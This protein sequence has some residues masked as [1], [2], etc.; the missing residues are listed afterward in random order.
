MEIRD[1]QVLITGAGQGIGRAV[2]QM[3]A[4][5]KA[6]LHLILKSDRPELEQELKKLGAASVK[7]YPVDLTKKEEVTQLLKSI[8]KIEIDLL[9]NSATQ[10]IGGLLEEQNFD[11]IDDMLQMNI[12]AMIQF[13]HAILPSMLRRKKGKII[14][15][16]SVTALINFPRAST[17][18][19]S[20][21][22]V[23]AFT[24]SLK[25]ELRGTG[26]STLI[27]VTPG[28]ETPVLKDIP[29]IFST[30]PK[31][32]AQMIREAVL[33]DLTELKPSGLPGAGLMVAQHIP[34]IFE[35]VVF[36]RFKR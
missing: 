20:K 26:V 34:K 5:D 4:E 2:A 1:S 15:H 35:N 33:E 8:Q 6:H 25:A 10:M 16:S 27:L 24:N 32:Y 28:T 19:A 30:S 18:A 13:T 22:A 29:K 9:F 12:N 31:Q 36:K 7:I 21:A 11:E 17:Y 23:L 3:C 14:N